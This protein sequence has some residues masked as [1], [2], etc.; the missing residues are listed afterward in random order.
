MIQN[1]SKM[2]PK[3]ISKWSQKWPNNDF[4][5]IPKTTP[6]WFQNDPKNDPKIIP[7]ERLRTRNNSK[8]LRDFELFLAGDPD[9]LH[10]RFLHHPPATIHQPPPYLPNPILEASMLR[11]FEASIHGNL[12]TFLWL[13]GWWTTMVLPRY[14]DG[15]AMVMR[16]LP[17]CLPNMWKS[18]K[19]NENRRISMKINKNQ[20]KSK[21]TQRK[22]MKS[23]EIQWKW[24]TI[25]EKSM[26]LHGNLW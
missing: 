14:C 2:I 26:K 10:H 25:H 22:S 5:M 23:N 3:I 13:E 16:R 7:L 21:E 8:S 17:P 18:M 15:T 12:R 20:W 4:Q 1:N 24:M 19:I 6:K 11:C 9:Y